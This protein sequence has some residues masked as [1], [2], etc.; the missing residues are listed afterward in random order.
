MSRS[1]ASLEYTCYIVES[2]ASDQLPV[3]YRGASGSPDLGATHNKIDGSSIYLA[4]PLE[5]YSS[6]EVGDGKIGQG[7]ATSTIE[8]FYF[9]HRILP[10]ER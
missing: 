1:I 3:V 8:C 6:R 7:R 2:K 5:L 10:P 9:Y 4:A